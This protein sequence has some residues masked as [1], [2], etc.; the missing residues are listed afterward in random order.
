MILLA[1]LF[2]RALRLAGIPILGVS[3]GDEADRSTWVV[4]FDVRATAQHRIDA[5]TL[6]KVFDP[7]AADVLMDERGQ[8]IAALSRRQDTLAT[9]AL[10]VR[11]RNVTAWN[12]LT[13]QQKITA[14]LTE[15]DAWAAVR[16]FVEQHL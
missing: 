3:I 15:S 16:D 12:A 8:R 10:V 2:D 11:S 7:T 1:A 13:D 5:D 9:C 4:R 6:R 14:I